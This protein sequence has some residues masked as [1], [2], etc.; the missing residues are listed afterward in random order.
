MFHTFLLLLCTN[1][2]PSM[3]FPTSR[4]TGRSTNIH[5]PK[6]RLSGVDALAH[7]HRRRSMLG[8]RAV[9][10]STAGS[11]TGTA[12]L[13]K[14]SI[15]AFYTLPVEIGNQEFQLASDTGSFDS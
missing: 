14:T 13:T 5:P 15:G 4:A 1:A 3:A 11:E 6:Q 9:K 7:S 8:S 2:F 12:Y 10:A